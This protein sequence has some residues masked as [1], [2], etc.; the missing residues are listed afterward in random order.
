ML[1]QLKTEFLW[2][3]ISLQ[4]LMSVSAIHV[5]TEPVKTL[6]DP[7]TVSATQG[8]NSPIITIVWVSPQSF[9][10]SISF[11]HNTLKQKNKIKE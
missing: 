10:A 6:L 1:F 11:L 7:I 8:L 4:M 5:E 2:A 3:N 9:S